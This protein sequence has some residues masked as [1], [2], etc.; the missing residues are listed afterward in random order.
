MRRLKFFRLQHREHEIRE[1]SQGDESNDEVF[2]RHLK[3]L[4]AVSV[5]FADDEEG[6]QD[7]DINEICHDTNLR[8]SCE[9][10]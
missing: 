6:H 1:Q 4:A 2:H 5:P 8:L 7:R 10:G 9:T 3:F